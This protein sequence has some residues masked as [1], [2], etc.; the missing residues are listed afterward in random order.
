MNPGRHAAARAGAICCNMDRR[1]RSPL[2]RRRHSPTPAPTTGAAPLIQAPHWS[3]AR[4]VIGV[5]VAVFA[6]S[7]RRASTP[8]RIRSE[9]FWIAAV[10][11]TRRGPS[12]KGAPARRRGWTMFRR[13]R[14]HDSSGEQHPS[15]F[16][17]TGAAASRPPPM[18]LRF[19]LLWSSSWSARAPSPANCHSDAFPGTDETRRRNPSRDPHRQR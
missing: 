9:R 15:S 5:G 14:A 18:S 4:G 16:G 2:Q 7:A 12:L 1:V 17:E 6:S 3:D 19:A 8:F 13:R 11:A 10:L